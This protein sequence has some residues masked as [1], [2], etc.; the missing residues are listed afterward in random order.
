MEWF[1]RCDPVYLN[2]IDLDLNLSLNSM[3]GLRE[4]SPLS[5]GN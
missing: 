2:S 4:T 5:I 1:M 3:T